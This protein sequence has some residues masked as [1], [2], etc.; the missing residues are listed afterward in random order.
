VLFG[1]RPLPERPLWVRL[2]IIVMF[3][4]VAVPLARFAFT[5]LPALG[6][7]RKMTAE[8]T[9][10]ALPSRL[11]WLP[12]NDAGR[13]IRC[14]EHRQTSD[15]SPERAG[16]WDYICTFAPQPRVSQKR[17]KVGVRVNHEGIAEMSAVYDLDARYVK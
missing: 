9:A 5:Q 6:L 14:D 7:A 16:A 8:E 12:R 4:G 15:W 10:A 13:D 1:G 17:V 11:S 2:L 3:L